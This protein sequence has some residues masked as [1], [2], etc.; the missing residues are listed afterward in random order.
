MTFR[1]SLRAFLTVCAGTLAALP[2]LADY[3][4]LVVFGDSMSDTHR[5]YEISKYIW[6]KPFPGPP[7]Y[8]GRVADGPVAVEYLAQNLKV[9]LLNYAFAGATSGYDSLLLFPLG[10]LTQ[11]NEYLN[12]N[13]IVP[14]PTTIPLVSTIAMQLP[15]S[16]KADPKAL[17]MIWA[18]P[19]DY[20]RPFI[21]MTNATT[22]PTIANIKQ[23]VTSLYNGG[24]RHFFIPMMPDLSL[25]PSALNHEKNNPGY[26]DAARRASDDFGVALVKALDELRARY[27]S[28]RIMTF[29]NLAYMRQQFPIVKAQGKIIDKACREGGLDLVSLRSTPATVCSNPQDHVFWDSNH[30]TSWVDKIWAGEWTKTILAAP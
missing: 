28:A 12:N 7:N 1:R 9:P 11:V 18:G 21:G 8:P 5:M 10:V 3:S 26:I 14:I 24:A 20:Y 25:T 2:A 30:P 27:P 22:P 6:T 4:K 17:H 23:A 13:A 19:D 15:T 16:G 29:D